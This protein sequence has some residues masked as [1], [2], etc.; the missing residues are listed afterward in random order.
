MTLPNFRMTH[1][2]KVL[3]N[4]LRFGAKEFSP[5]SFKEFIT[6]DLVHYKTLFSKLVKVILVKSV[7]K[8]YHLVTQSIGLDYSYIFPKKTPKT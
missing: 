3:T 6:K 4:Y 5:K 7:S 8:D 1:Y 2:I